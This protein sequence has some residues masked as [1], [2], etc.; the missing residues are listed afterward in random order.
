MSIE[1]QKS[2]FSEQAAK[3]LKRIEYRRADTADE[4]DK[5]IRLR[6]KAYLKEGAIAASPAE[7]LEDNFDILENA[8]NI[9]VY[10]DG[11]LAS[12]L[13][14]HIVAKENPCS[15]AMESFSDALQPLLDQSKV[16]I[17][18]NRFVAD[19]EIAR[20]YPELPFLTLR[21]ANLA[22]LYFGGNYVTMTVRAE[23]QA[24][25]RRGF[26]AQ[27]V[28]PPR[29]YP[30]LSKPISLLLVDYDADR[31]RIEARHPYWM[32][33]EPERERLFG[34]GPTYIAKAS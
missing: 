18:P 5:I 27:V 3:L 16:I 28:C 12:A 2:S 13:R 9:G 15:P 22:A 17:D 29:N 7:R 30:L 25:Y 32:S 31:P 21:L 33:S 19:Y 34:P 14:L 11:K 10:I 26:F 8:H 24:F 4:L 1:I 23:H 6:Y 20:H